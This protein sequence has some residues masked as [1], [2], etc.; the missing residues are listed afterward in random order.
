MRVVYCPVGFA[1][2]FLLSDVA[3]VMYKQ[4]NHYSDEHERRIAD[5]DV[6][7]AIERPVDASEIRVSQRDASAPSLAG[8]A[9]T[10]AFRSATDGGGGSG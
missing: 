7:S 3:D 4:G 10:L 8:V 6:D 1:H 9:D 5:N 2:G